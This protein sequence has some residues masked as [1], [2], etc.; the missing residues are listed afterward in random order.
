MVETL[1][2]SGCTLKYPL[3]VQDLSQLPDTIH[4]ARKKIF[5]NCCFIFYVDQGFGDRLGL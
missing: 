3:A 5:Q 4:V 2:K 1:R